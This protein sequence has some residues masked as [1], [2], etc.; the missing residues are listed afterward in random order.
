MPQSFAGTVSKVG[1]PLPGGPEDPSHGA[2]GWVVNV[3]PWTHRR[4]TIGRG[5]LGATNL[6]VG[7]HGKVYVTEL[8]GNRVSVLEHGR[9]HAVAGRLH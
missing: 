6:A 4:G 5:I 9:P 1:Q 8:F 7:H 3:N 2:R